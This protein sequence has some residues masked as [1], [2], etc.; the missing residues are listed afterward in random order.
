MLAFGHVSN[1][2]YALA[3]GVTLTAGATLADAPQRVVSMNL[4]TDQLALMLADEGQLIAVSDIA[5]DPLTSAMHEEAAGFPVTHGGAEEIFLLQPDLVLAG[6]YSDPVAIAMLRSLGI[7]V[8]QIDIANRL[9]DIPDR[10]REIGELLGRTDA[11]ER[12]IAEF[13]ADLSR[14]AGPEGGPR[15]AF[16]YPNGYTLGTGSLSHDIITHVG[17]T[18]I[19]DELSRSASGRVA[20]ELMVLADPEL[21]IGSLPYPGASR[22]EEILRH[23]ALLSLTEQARGAFSGPDW[24]CG[25]PRVVGALA[26]M[27]AIRAD[28]EAN[29]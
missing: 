1:W 14:L 6:I 11:A 29:Q 5:S 13:Q 9:S 2:T 23:P 19:A 28:I 15:A 18:H 8:A 20:L 7:E 4:C 27:A 21:I 12:L 3:V 16:Y 25:T 26:H 17:L 10:A 22:S 24:I